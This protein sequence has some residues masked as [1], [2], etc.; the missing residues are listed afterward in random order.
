MVWEYQSRVSYNHSW[1]PRVFL[2][3][4]KFKKSANQLGLFNE[5]K[6]RASTIVTE[7]TFPTKIE[8]INSDLGG[9]Q[10]LF[11]SCL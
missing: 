6:Y 2:S 10:N 11:V 5:N 1:Q 4:Y 7:K 9:L 3:L 8:F